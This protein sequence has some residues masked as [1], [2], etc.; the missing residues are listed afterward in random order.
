[1]DVKTLT[2]KF[3]EIIADTLIVPM[4]EGEGTNEALLKELNGHTEGA[5]AS[6]L[7]HR[8]FRGKLN[9]VAYIHRAPGLKARRLL[10]VGVGKREKFSHFQ[11]RQAVG[12]S[13]RILKNKGVQTVAWVVR[14]NLNPE[15]S[16]TAIVDAMLA[17]LFEPDSYK[18]KEREERPF[19]QFLII[20]PESIRVPIEVGA[21]R[22]QIVGEAVNFARQLI[23]EPSSNLTP[24]IMA[25]Q[26]EQL[27]E[28][29]PLNIDVLNEAQMRELG[30]G[31]LLGVAR[32][33]NEEARLIVLKY[34]HPDAQ[35][36]ETIAF[37]GKGITFD[38]GGISIKP[39]EGMEK[40]K[41]DMAGAAAVMGAMRAIAQL[42][43]RARIVGVMACAENMPSGTAIKPGDVLRSMSGKTI[44]VINT[45][46]EGRLVLADAITYAKQKLGATRLVDLA[47]LTG[48][49]SIVLGPVYAGLLSNDETM[50]NSLI[51]AGQ[52][53]GERL[54]QLPLDEEYGEQ[55]RSDIA[56]LKNTGGRPAGMITAGYFLKE[57][58]GDTPWAH[59][60]IASTAWNSEKK[61]YISKG[62]TGIGVRLL[63]NWI[64]SRD[65]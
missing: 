43:P 9:E 54:W 52:E 58:A 49:C 65:K 30:M 2:D 56:D 42:K 28:G 41:Y 11:L 64:L 32:G 47:T 59:L 6:I 26:A 17:S 1:M 62:P 29:L 44:E 10:L 18:T 36:D 51:A 39:S 21:T 50:S 38:S 27:A 63:A 25:E 19:N 12:T 24:K 13:A 3:H 61:P 33:S 57:F 40:M 34:E 14:D 4:Y 16:A 22:G 60:D 20:V 55:L 37:I 31:A 7:E 48:A 5:L 46:A 35:N 15:M 23:N 53:V 45:D 8:E